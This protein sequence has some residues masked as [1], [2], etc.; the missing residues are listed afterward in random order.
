MPEDLRDHGKS[1]EEIDQGT[2]AP[3]RPESATDEAD[4]N[5]AQS[6]SIQHRQQ[7]VDPLGQRQRQRR[8]V[9]YAERS[10][11]RGAD[12]ISLSRTSRL[13]GTDGSPEAAA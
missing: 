9:R 10:G 12:A 6:E 2:G 5:A 3:A 4:H 7:P 11:T 13:I 1:T 8:I